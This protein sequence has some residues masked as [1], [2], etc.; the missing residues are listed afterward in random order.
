MKKIT[1]IAF[2]TLAVALL[3]KAQETRPNILLLIADQHSGKVLTQNGY[4]YLK[5]PGIDKLA[6][7]GV[8]FTRSYCTYPVCTASRSSFM[9]GVM[10]SKSQPNLTSYPGLGNALKNAGYETAYFGKWHVGHSKIKKV[11]D[12]HGFSVYKDERDDSKTEAMTID[13]LKQKHDAPFF[14][15]SSYLNPHDCCELARNI[16]GLGDNYHDGPVEEKMAVDQCPPL[17]VNFAIPPDEAEGFYC[18]RTPDPSDRVMFGKH[19]VKYWGETE[20]RQYMYGY[21]RLVE[22]M[23]SHIL[24]VVNTL[25]KQGLLENTIIFYTSDHGDGHASHQWNQKMNF[26]EESVNIPFII[27][28]KGHTKAGVIDSKVLLSNGLDLYPTICKL[29]GADYD[30]SLLGEDIS[31]YL[32]GHSKKLTKKRKY[33]V[34][35][36]NQETKTEDGKVV[37]K[38]RMVVSQR[39]KY[40]LFDGGE[41]REQFFDLKNDPGELKPVTDDPKYK[42]QLNIHRQYLKEWIE[43]ASD[44]FLITNIPQI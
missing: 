16:S 6:D 32:L 42:K 35:E 38:G 1:L 34:S 7:E 11:E 21:D 15:V 36:I 30:E 4:P 27:S 28:W 9:T 14:L 5:T 25:E 18:R 12:W 24:S 19:P 3:S 2:F 17:P 26:Y 43:N 44:E 40:F 37:F 41:N 39:Y 20:W 23:D 31:Q 8:T 29:A 33:V 22:K 10:P 13:F